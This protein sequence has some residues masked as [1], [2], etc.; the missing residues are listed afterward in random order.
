MVSIFIDS[1]IDNKCLKIKK[2][3]L[4][5]KKLKKEDTKYQV[6]VLLRFIYR[7]I[8]SLQNPINKLFLSQSQVA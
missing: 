3:K 6:Y 1:L 4:D 7:K 5:S 2:N 8:L